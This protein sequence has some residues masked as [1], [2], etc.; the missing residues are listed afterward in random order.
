MAMTTA[1]RLVSAYSTACCVM[2]PAASRGD[3]E[4]GR[5][6]ACGDCRLVH[7]LGPGAADRRVPGDQHHGDLGLDRLS[8]GGE[9]VGVAGAVGGGA[10][11][12]AS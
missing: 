10:R 4:G 12:E 5:A 3:G 7:V 9:C 6:E 11:C 2:A 8:E 1:V